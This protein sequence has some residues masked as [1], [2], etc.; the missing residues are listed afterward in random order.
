MK[1][2]HS[3]KEGAYFDEY[4]DKLAQSMLMEDTMPRLTH[5][6]WYWSELTGLKIQF[7]CYLKHVYVYIDMGAEMPE[8]GQHPSKAKHLAIWLEELEDTFGYRIGKTRRESVDQY[9][10]NFYWDGWKH[11]PD[12]T[13][14]VAHGG[15]C[16]LVVKSRKMVEQCEYETVCDD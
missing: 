8:T 10:Q 2:K 7:G 5:L 1:W 3:E 14:H 11:F 16:R 9:D 4:V 13:V 6:E 12:V 15:N